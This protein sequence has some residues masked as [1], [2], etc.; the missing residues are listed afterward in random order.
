MALLA[1]AAAGAA[2]CGGS[3]APASTTP[4]VTAASPQPAS[5]LKEVTLPDS[6][7]ADATVQAQLRQRYAAAVAAGQ[8]AALSRDARGEAY[9]ALA[10]LLHAG[11]YYDAAEPAY[12]NAQTLSPTQ[13][14]WPYLLAHLYR[15]R[16]QTDQ[17]QAAFTRALELNPNDVATLVWLGRG[18]LDQGD[19]GKAEP[20][21]A[22]ARAAEPKALAALA[23]LGQSALARRDFA[24]A[25]SVLEEALTL[26]PSAASL[27]SPLA[28]AYRGLGDTGKAEAHL[29]QWRNTDVVVEDPVREELD[30]ALQSGLSFELRGVRAL[31][32]R[33]FAAAVEYF[34]QGVAITP[35][36]IAI[37]RSLRHKLGTA[38]FLS[39]DLPGAVRRFEE[40]VRAAPEGGTDESVAKAHY[41]L[42]VLM[43]SAGRREAAIRHLAAA[44]RNNPNYVEALQALGDQQRRTGQFAA[45]LETYGSLLRVSPRAPEARVGYGVAL[46]RLRRFP[47]AKEWF[48]EGVRLYPDRGELRHALARLLAASPADGQR[49]GA[50][51]LTIVEELLKTDK[52]T[53][54]G[55]TMAMAFAEIGRF[56]QAV[57]VQRDIIGA[58]SKAGLTAEVRI[59]AENLRRYERGQPCRVPW[60]DADAIHAP[61]PPVTPGLDAALGS[62]G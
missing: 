28:M 3:P 53:A 41:S 7:R 40:T 23:G 5:A 57:A 6:S 8:N 2:A 50:R 12:L 43:A 48:E 15:S 30:L 24:G 32:S 29:R 61:G 37:G 54:L 38:L 4:P 39:G 56:D 46:V 58:A 18:Y 42:G 49:D 44:V 11:E 51:A 27:H 25:A 60:A 45:A 52:T 55:E 14:K 26:D 17:S 16:G 33:D 35:G 10:I 1:G 22:R 13:A 59:M 36:T 9:G 19:A 20:L 31:E 34:R 47:E 21:F 62:A